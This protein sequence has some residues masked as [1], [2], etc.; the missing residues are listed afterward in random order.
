MAA[1]KKLAYTLANIIPE[2]KNYGSNIDFILTKIPIEDQKHAKIR[3]KLKQALD[4]NQKQNAHDS[5]LIDFLLMLRKKCTNR[6]AVFLNPIE[7]DLE[8]TM[9]ELF[10][11]KEWISVP[12]Q[13]IRSF[14][15]DDS[16]AKIKQQ[17]SK[18]KEYIMK[19]M[20]RYQN[21][22]H[23]VAASESGLDF[24]II[25]VK[26]SELYDLHKCLED[27]QI[28][29]DTLN[30]CI[31][32]IKESFNGKITNAI[33]KLSNANQYHN[34]REFEK[35]IID[36]KSITKD[37][38]AMMDLQNKKYFENNNGASPS[39]LNESLTNAF[40]ASLEKC[41][42]MF[43]SAIY[44]K[45]SA[46]FVEYFEQF[47]DAYSQKMNQISEEL[48]KI[49]AESTQYIKEHDVKLYKNLQLL[50]QAMHLNDNYDVTAT[51][52]YL[53]KELISSL[54]GLLT[55]L[56]SDSILQDISSLEWAGHDVQLK[57][58]NNTI[59]TL[60]AFHDQL[61]TL[62]SQLSLEIKRIHSK[63]IKVMVDYCDALNAIVKSILSTTP[64]KDTHVQNTM[65]K[66]KL[67]MTE[68]TN[69]YGMNE[70]VKMQTSP[71][72]YQTTSLIINYLTNIQDGF[73]RI[74][75]RIENDIATQED[76]IVLNTYVQI[77][78]HSDWIFEIAGKSKENELIKH[79]TQQLTHRIKKLEHESK[80]I[81]PSVDDP[82]SL[83][84]IKNVLDKLSKIRF[85]ED[86]I[87]DIATMSEGV[88]NIVQNDVRR[89]L[90][91]VTREY[92]SNPSNSNRVL[93]QILNKMDKL[94]K[95]N[96]DSLTM[97][98]PI[99]QMVV[100]L[101]HQLAQESKSND[102]EN[103]S[104][105]LK[106][107][108]Q[109]E[110]FANEMKDEGL[111]IR[112]AI[113]INTLRAMLMNAMEHDTNKNKKLKF[114][115]ISK[116]L[117]FIK[118]CKPIPWVKQ[119]N[120]A[121]NMNVVA[122]NC[123]ATVIDYLNEYVRT[124]DKQLQHSFN[125]LL[126]IENGIDDRTLFTEIE[127]LSDVL[128][129]YDAIK[130]KEE[131]Y[132][133]IMN[134][135][136]EDTN[137]WANWERLIKHKFKELQ[138]DLQTFSKTDSSRLNIA[139][140]RARILNR[141]D[142]FL[143][144]HFSITNGFGSL[145]SEYLGILLDAGNLDQ[146]ASALESQNFLEA[147]DLIKPLYRLKE[148]HERKRYQNARIRLRHKACE[149]YDSFKSQIIRLID[150]RRRNEN[151]LR[152]NV[153]DVM[154]QYQVIKDIRTFCH[155]YIMEKDIQ[156]LSTIFSQA[157][158]LLVGH[159]N[160]IS[161][162]ATRLI[163]SC[164]FAAAEELIG[165]YNTIVNRLSD[166]FGDK[167]HSLK[168]KCRTMSD[169]VDN[170][171]GDIYKQ[172]IDEI[173]FDDNTIKQRTNLYGSKYIN[174]RYKALMAAHAATQN[175]KYER[176]WHDIRDDINTK[177]RHLLKQS[178][179]A[180]WKDS[181][182][183]LS[184]C[185]DILTSLP[186]TTSDVLQAECQATRDRIKAANKEETQE[187][188]QFLIDD[189]IASIY[190]L[191]GKMKKEGNRTMMRTIQG[192]LSDKARQ[193][194]AHLDHAIA[195]DDVKSM[196]KDVAL[197]HHLS[198]GLPSDDQSYKQLEAQ[199]VEARTKMDTFIS[200]KIH[201][202][203]KLIYA[204]KQQCIKELH[205][206]LDVLLSSFGDDD[207]SIT[208][209]LQAKV[210]DYNAQISKFLNC[211]FNEQMEI[212][213]DALKNLDSIALDKSLNTMQ[214]FDSTRPN[215]IS[216]L[217]SFENVQISEEA[218]YMTMIS[219][220]RDKLHNTQKEIVDIG[221]IK[222]KIQRNAK[223]EHHNYFLYLKDQL[224]SLKQCNALKSHIG[225]TSALYESCV[226]TLEL[227]LKGVIKEL[228][229][230][231]NDD[232]SLTEDV[233][234]YINDHYRI[235]LALDDA[236]IDI[237]SA[238]SGGKKKKKKHKKR[239]STLQSEIDEIAVLIDGKLSLLE[240]KLMHIIGNVHRIDEM[241]DIW[242]QMEMMSTI[243]VDLHD[244][245][246]SKIENGLKAFKKK[247]P[248]AINALYA[249]L[250]HK[251]N[252]WAHEIQSYS[253]FHAI[254]VSQFNKATAPYGIEHVLK[255]IK[256]IGDDI[257]TNSKKDILCRLFK[258][259]KQ[260]YEEVVDQYLLDPSRIDLLPLIS[261]IKGIPGDLKQSQKHIVW[262]LKTKEKAINL[263]SYIFALW[264]L[265]NSK[266][267][268]EVADKTDARSYLMTP[269]DAQVISIFRLL[270]LGNT[271]KSYSAVVLSELKELASKWSFGLYRSHKQAETLMPNLVEIGTGEGKSLTLAV[272]SAVLALLG[273]HVDCACYSKY[274]SV[275]DYKDFESLFIS[276]D[277]HHHIKYGTFNELS[278]NIINEDGNIRDIVT[279]L[280]LTED[281]QKSGANKCYSPKRYARANVLLIDEVDVFFN[282]QFYGQFY[283]PGAVLKHECIKGITDYIWNHYTKNGNQS[284]LTLS[285][286]KATNEYE[287]CVKVFEWADI[288]DEQVKC[289][290]AD[291]NTFESPKY[292]VRNDKIGYK[293]GDQISY[294]ATVGYKTL[295][296][297]YHEHYNHNN[298]IST[299]SLENMTAMYLKCG[300]FSYAEIP[301][302]FNVIMGVTGTLKH[303]SRSQLQIMDQDYGLKVHSYMPS[304][305]GIN[306]HKFDEDEDIKI[307]M[308][309]QFNEAL[310]N[311]IIKRLKDHAP[312]TRC[313]F[314]FFDDRI[315]LM[316]FYNSNAFIAFH[317]RTRIITEQLTFKEKEAEIKRA[318]QSNRITLLTKPFGRG[319]D[320][321]VM[322]D[323][324]KNNGGPHV[325]QTFV[326]LELSEQI[327]IRGRTAR[328]GGDGSYSMVLIDEELEKFGITK[329]DI[330]T[331]EQK[332]D[333]YGMIQTKRTA[334]F[335]KE[336]MQVLDRIKTAKE[337][338]ESGE[339]FLRALHN[340][341]IDKV[342]EDLLSYNVG[343]ATG[344]VKIAICV[345]ATGSMTSLLEST[346]TRIREMFRRIRDILHEH[347]ID[348]NRFQI[349][350]IAYRNYNA[351]AEELLLSSGWQNDPNELD[352][353]LKHVPPDYGWGNEA[354]E[355]A[356]EFVNNDPLVDEMIII[357]DAPPN[358][359]AE[360]IKK[361][362]QRK[363]SYWE[364]T[365]Y[366]TAVY[367]DDELIKLKSRGL[368]INSFYLRE[369]AKNE[370]EKMAQTT[371]GNCERLDIDSSEGGEQLTRLISTTVLNVCGGEQ[372]GAQLVKAYDAKFTHIS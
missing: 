75:T 237:F 368:K 28:I 129:E 11:D 168:D 58:M 154:K 235:L 269:H 178:E 220:T 147:A 286:I 63:G 17:I 205:H 166:L 294:T 195:N 86:I 137:I 319:T 318:P 274:L 351:P 173:T 227:E 116:C 323:A 182:T 251:Q 302:R 275:R 106:M 9:E 273:F 60:Q 370:F 102:D 246:K 187:L 329:E 3:R 34:I 212:F 114:K 261:T 215:I 95:S 110:Q 118:A 112:E 270:G 352:K 228:K 260:R 70:N 208:K 103:I 179:Q 124:Q 134:I 271:A 52:E 232:A 280:M 79:I 222:R 334:E 96:D 249:L 192:K 217:E 349:Q 30:E 296:A 365:K 8:E 369:G 307:T 68:F 25:D 216:K 53:E 181:V 283:T 133:D 225:D 355:V 244:K 49:K 289:M 59:K 55:D 177:F 285:A 242:T 316:S 288:I 44:F 328:Q 130:R 139:I 236:D 150:S 101:Q 39:L 267:Y 214:L 152:D 32:I 198:S 41:S 128:F 1:L 360:V 162:R 57:K 357:G 48:D 330:E 356:L 272:S 56:P 321:K 170:K 199:Y 99:E 184:L 193:T 78:N 146:I 121:D 104:R 314:V 115:K 64:A 204:M 117:I 207:N 341:D 253:I 266:S 185:D 306:K 157:I 98:K 226:S 13:V 229:R 67:A 338:H 363:Q 241:I 126:N 194:H 7:S 292:V 88:V 219:K 145:H 180:S 69:I 188:E 240:K 183:I 353:F 81:S 142:W 155:E 27:I 336:Y 259:F 303:L 348:T 83:Q 4:E 300:T 335:A 43:D 165:E 324:V 140:Q 148:A 250:N 202:I 359:K 82:E 77:M 344:S 301:K 111:L 364:T 284:I 123:R 186:K 343:P 94:I 290:L 293:E 10:S 127:T 201:D 350:L 105:Q 309:E 36:Y 278:E 158:S 19:T 6:T 89:I 345:D 22:R 255:H 326:S 45:K 325:I 21:A 71:V 169:S 51:I 252:T 317:D 258:K 109:F 87:P 287:E 62:H 163:G 144:S 97:D 372:Q 263:M 276:L 74:L 243:I 268:F 167:I 245:A 42:L 230:K 72:Y 256:G 231:L 311:E 90:A 282:K 149:I 308:I 313:V 310:K 320:F 264:T 153:N 234:D 141:I 160:D 159:I 223:N 176:V 120:R 295:F 143:E 122:S 138:I 54:N 197:L 23:D 151:E 248:T 29:R 5:A 224:S 354:V 132:H 84:L 47:K 50:G 108:T 14:V 190:L 24:E 209:I 262:D 175:G 91:A 136:Y 18:H 16:M 26:L 304:L 213:S 66:A 20:N 312:A 279:D 107:Y 297:Y 342:K 331:A 191:F 281:E 371:G 65:K 206:N 2:Y 164:T 277:I 366:K 265:Q 367:F 85:L 218:K 80:R 238:I 189:D 203:K 125:V 113:D 254:A 92:S 156:T 35:S 131:E 298:V 233:C 38:K 257:N 362:N 61:N 291:I 210:N 305:F 135:L 161:S 358:T 327:Q 340:N 347:H 172:F 93:T 332:H 239:K 46:I 196:K 299:Q 33:T 73:T 200:K 40:E 339:E 119:F 333:L 37:M 31:Q 15:T 346:K 76:Y 211:Y 315:K 174:T 221:L 337:V 247:N 322:D 171:L 12:S 361:R 100:A